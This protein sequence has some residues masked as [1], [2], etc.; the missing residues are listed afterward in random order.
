MLITELSDSL[1]KAKVFEKSE[2]LERPAQEILAPYRAKDGITLNTNRV[3]SRIEK[4]PSNTMFAPIRQG[5]FVQCPFDVG[6]EH[7][8]FLIRWDGSVETV[9]PVA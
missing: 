8:Q 9:Y 6:Q 2:F 4:C 7:D 3:W 5:V 1:M